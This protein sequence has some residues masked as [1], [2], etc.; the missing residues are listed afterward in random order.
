VATGRH[1]LAIWQNVSPHDLPSWRHES[2]QRRAALDNSVGSARTDHRARL[3]S[4]RANMA[5]S[6]VA[7][8]HRA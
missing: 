2:A 1:G 8:V 4:P 5:R 6:V 7:M 3:A